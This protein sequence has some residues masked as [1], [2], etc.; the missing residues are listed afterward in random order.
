[1]HVLNAKINIPA[2][3]EIQ[4]GI[5]ESGMVQKRRFHSNNYR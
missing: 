3:K 1:M 5:G 2:L 4:R